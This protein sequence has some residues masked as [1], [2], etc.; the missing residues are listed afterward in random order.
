MVLGLVGQRNHDVFSLN[1]PLSL[2]SRGTLKKDLLKTT[3]GISRS[4][5]ITEKASWPATKTHETLTKHAKRGQ[6]CQTCVLA[7]PGCLGSDQ[8]GTMS[9]AQK[10]TDA[11]HKSG[12]KRKCPCE[13]GFQQN[14]HPLNGRHGQPGES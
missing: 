2:P 4:G 7:P 6:K 10:Q 13:G 12:I 14:I 3:T 8:A 11:P 5:S 9:R 1:C